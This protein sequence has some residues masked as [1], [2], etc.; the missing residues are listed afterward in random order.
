MYVRLSLLAGS[1]TLL[2]AAHAAA[3]VSASAHWIVFSAYPKGF[4]PAQLFRVQTTGEGLEQITTGK[5]IATDPAFAPNGKQIVFS[6]L[7]VGIFVANLDGSGLRRL[8]K[9]AH[10]HFPVWSPNG[11]QI[12][13]LRV[14]GKA[15]R[16]HVLSP[17]GGKPR[18][19][20]E[21]PPAGR[22]SWRADS[23][24]IFVPALG[25]LARVN[26]R[27]G[28]LE[29]HIAISIDPS[30]GQSAT[31]SPNSRSVVF[32]GNRPSGE[33][34]GDAS[35]VRYALF[36]APIPGHRARRFAVDTGP[37]G[38]SPD[39]KSLVFVYRHGLQVWPIAGGTHKAIAVGDNV[40]TGD[41]PPAW[42]PR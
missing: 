26:A 18:L 33:G 21:A 42:Q 2:L 34:C 11:K 7:G 1:I 36:L 25:A 8:T 3:G 32:L 39:S 20:R 6:R 13:F 17:A 40:P 24:A 10:D 29:R 5:Q 28:K 30:T 22:P 14:I 38:W 12:A 27:T 31:L 4:P 35:C 37:A 9:G 23:K 16:L 15:W 41:A 19:L